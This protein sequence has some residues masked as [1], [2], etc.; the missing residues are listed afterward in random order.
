[1]T[2]P[3]LTTI[4]I[5]AITVSISLVSLLIA[6]LI[7]VRKDSVATGRVVAKVEEFAK[8][9]SD[10]IEAVRGFKQTVDDLKIEFASIRN[11][12]AGERKLVDKIRE[13]ELELVKLRTEH[14]RFHPHESGPIPT[15]RQEGAPR[16]LCGMDDGGKK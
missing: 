1:M 14:D 5:A 9:Q 7:A 10:I 13:L 6:V 11:M 8:Q 15:H 3:M 2:P 12:W 16:S 4:I